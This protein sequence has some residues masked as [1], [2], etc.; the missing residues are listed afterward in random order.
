MANI[1]LPLIEVVH[2]DGFNIPP[3]CFNLTL[4]YGLMSVWAKDDPAGSEVSFARIPNGDIVGW[5]LIVENG[6]PVYNI[7]VYTREDYRQ[8]GVGRLVL[9]HNLY[10]LAQ[11]A[12]CAQVWYGS[13]HCYPFNPVFD[14]EIKSVGLVPEHRY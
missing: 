14:Q 3:V 10:H 9:R 4:R 12:P 2:V 5:C 6:P 1:Y 7:A 13:T 11:R 8:C